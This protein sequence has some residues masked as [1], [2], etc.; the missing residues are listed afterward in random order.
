M[1]EDADDFLAHYGVLGMHWGIRHDK[2]SSGKHSLTQDDKDI[3]KR[4]NLAEADSDRLMDKYGPQSEKKKGFSEGQKTALVVGAYALGAIA[5][6]GLSHYAANKSMGPK[7]LRQFL[8]K[9]GSLKTLLSRGLTKSNVVNLGK[10]PY[11]FPVGQIFK[12]VSMDAENEISPGGF[13]AA[14]KPNDVERYKAVLPVYWKMWAKNLGKPVSAATHGFVIDLKATK[15]IKAPSERDT[16]EL[17]KSFM[18]DQVKVGEQSDSVAHSMAVALG[19]GSKNDDEIA[20]RIFPA[21]AQ[22]WA[23]DDN[24]FVASFLTSLKDLVITLSL[25]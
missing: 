17:F 10:E 9:S 13:Y 22:A 16:F 21:F 11:N 4:A 14:F 3:L 23:Q 19:I 24:P 15:E 12:R 1:V 20:R 5:I 7:A 2:E 8:E 6:L 25:I 18:H